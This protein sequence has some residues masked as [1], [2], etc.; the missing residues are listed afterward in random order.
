MKVEL[1]NISKRYIRSYILK[2]VNLSIPSGAVLGISGPNGSGK[3]T[4]IKIISGYL[5]QSSGTIDYSLNDQRINPDSLYKTV[6]VAAP[7]VGI[8]NEFNIKEQLSFHQSF[9]PFYTPMDI[10]AFLDVLGVDYDREKQIQYYSSGMQHRV[11]LALA[12]LSKSDLLILDEP[13]SFLDV[14]AK[15]WFFDFLK[16]RK[17]DR[18]II[19]ASNE[20][21]DFQLCNQVVSTNDWK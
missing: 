3:S 6:S 21:E 4:L 7:Y 1:K 13:S 14:N 15:R 19:V 12:V 11:K 8:I 16:K 20:Q 5:A 10:Q 2:N 9:K 18:T 17:L